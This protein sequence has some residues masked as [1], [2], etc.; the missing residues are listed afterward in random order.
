MTENVNQRKFLRG[1][2]VAG[3]AAL[4]APAVAQGSGETLKM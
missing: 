1:S 2:V 3:A 4:A